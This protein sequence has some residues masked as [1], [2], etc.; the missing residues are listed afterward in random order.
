MPDYRLHTATD[1]IQ[2]LTTYSYRLHTATDYIQLPTTYIYR[3]HTAT[4]YIQLPTTYRGQTTDYI[5][6]PTTYSC[7]LHTAADY[8]QWPDCQ[9]H[10]ATESP[11]TRSYTDYM[12]RPVCVGSSAEPCR[13]YNQEMG[14]AAP[15]GSVRPVRPITAGCVGS[16]PAGRTPGAAP[17]Q[18]GSPPS[19][20]PSSR[21]HLGVRPITPPQLTCRRVLG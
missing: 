16:A 21:G 3:L 6:L 9:L 8:I 7:R 11:T 5:Q 20:P 13:W 2:L 17:A 19:A 10:T 1:Y 14:R 4:D 18:M 15:M 12:Q